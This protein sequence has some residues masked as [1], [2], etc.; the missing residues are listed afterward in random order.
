M[1]QSLVHSRRLLFEAPNN[2]PWASEMVLN[3]GIIQD[4]VTGR[5]HMLVRTTGPCP[6]KQLPGCPLPFPIFLAY[7]WSDD[8]G[9]TW[10]ADFSRPA[11]APKVCYEIDELYIRNCNGETVVNHANGCI[12]DPRLIILD[13]Q[14]YLIVA[15]RLMPPGPYWEVDQPCQCSPA[16]ISTDKNPFGKAALRN[17]TVNVLFKVD[18]ARLA[19]KDY[20]RAF[21]YVIHLTNPEF[22][23]DRDVVLFSEKLTINGRKQYVCIH[24]PVRPANYPF[25]KQDL[26]P[27]IFVCASDDLKTIWKETKTQTLM[28]EPA[29]PWEGNRIGASAL[30]LRI[31]DTEWLLCYHG[32]QDDAVGYTQ[33]FMILEE[34]PDDFPRVTH[35]CPERLMY[36]QEPWEMPN[37]F[38]TPCVFVTGLIRVGDALMISYGAADQRVGIAAID[39]HALL[40]HLRRFPV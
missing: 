28:A 33:S 3:P 22:G 1:T 16:W 35:R 2:S 21:Q 26:P 20:D 31:S 29:F 14:C 8:N 34:Q 6:E 12:E 15:C 17:V 30:P 9:K 23:E 39:F 5:I 37:K 24:R 10:Q 18:L 25:V 40:K 27:S 32:K 38:K 13:G 11:L 36:A 19:G 4:P 7:A